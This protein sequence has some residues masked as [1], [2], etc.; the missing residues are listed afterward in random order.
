M[1][2]DDGNVLNTKEAVYFVATPITF[3][4]KNQDGEIAECSWE[5]YEITKM[6]I[7]YPDIIGVFE[8][9]VEYIRNK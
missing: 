5:D 1:F 2:D 6:K 9:A 4:L 8:E 3:D 7:K